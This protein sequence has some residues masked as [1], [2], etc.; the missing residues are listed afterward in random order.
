MRLFDRDDENYL[1]IQL[2]LDPHERDMLDEVAATEPWPGFEKAI[3]DYA[4]RKGLGSGERAKLR[5][6]VYFWNGGIR[7]TW[8]DPRYLDPENRERF[9]MAVRAHL[10]LRPDAKAVVVIA[11]EGR[12][13]W[14][15]G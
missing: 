7:L 14:G 2:L 10:D 6:A 3:D 12:V 11:P 8:E 9:V 5:I 15:A 4:A 13:P 1:P